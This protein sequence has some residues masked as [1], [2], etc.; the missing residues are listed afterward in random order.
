MDWRQ[1]QTYEK[2]ELPD[3]FQEGFK[4]ADGIDRKY[5]KGAY[6]EKKD[7]DKSQIK[8][9]NMLQVAS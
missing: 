6:E 4:L 9:E 1:K 7:E 8:D 5:K 2:K 3:E